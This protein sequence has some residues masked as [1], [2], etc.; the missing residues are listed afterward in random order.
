MLGSL[1]GLLEPKRAPLESRMGSPQESI[2]GH[3]LGLSPLSTLIRRRLLGVLWHFPFSR[4]SSASAHLRGRDLIIYLEFYPFAFELPDCRQPY[5]AS[6]S[7]Y[8]P[9]PSPSRSLLF[10][11]TSIFSNCSSFIVACNQKFLILPCRKRR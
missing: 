3:S 10:P 7:N 11:L 8:K 1:I 2:H 4:L 6:L 9:P 5:P